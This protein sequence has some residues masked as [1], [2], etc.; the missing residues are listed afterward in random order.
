MMPLLVRVIAIVAILLVVIGLS[1]SFMKMQEVPVLKIRVSVTTDT[2]DKN[3]SVHVNAL[4]R[5][6][7]NMMNVPRTNFEEFPAVQAY[8]AVNM[9]RN[10]SQWVTSPYK[11]AGDYE[12]T[13]SF[14]SE[15]EDE[16]IIMVLVWVVDAKGK[17]ISDIVRIMNKWS[18]IQS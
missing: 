5:E 18:E 3:V 7:M 1:V 15:P 8:V 16:D 4:K 13:A 2:N 9:G 12:L 17:R 14:R 11:G 6:R 10:G